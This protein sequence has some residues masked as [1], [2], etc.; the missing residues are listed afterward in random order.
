MKEL[1]KLLRTVNQDLKKDL[2]NKTYEEQHVLLV[3]I[4]KDLI[5]LDREVQKLQ[6]IIST[7]NE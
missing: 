6:K 7:G 3:K 2:A 1:V 5:E 4:K